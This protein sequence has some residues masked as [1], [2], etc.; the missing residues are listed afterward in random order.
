MSETAL[1]RAEES[2]STRFT[3]IMNATTS[4][5]GV[6]TDPVV[7]GVCTAPPLVALVA[8]VRFE[9]APALVTALEGLAAA[10][11]TLA[12]LLALALRGARAGVVA[13]LA[14]LPFPL[15]N[16]NAVLNGLGETLLVSFTGACPATDEL[17]KLL[18]PVSA[19]AFVTERGEPKDGENGWVEVRIGVVDDKR[20]PAASNHRR[21]ER[22]RALVVEVL[23]PLG[24]RFPIAEVRV[25]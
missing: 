1:A 13:W 11:L 15:E 7:V 12:V 4:R 18:D 17:N 9:A 6:L 5:F 19:E 24:A 23:V 14:G 8:A 21:F 16:L 22:V 25:K 3:R 10:P 20:N 2:V